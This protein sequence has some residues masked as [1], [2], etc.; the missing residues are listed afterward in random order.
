M[1]SLAFIR[2]YSLEIFTFFLD[3]MGFPSAFRWVFVTGSE[4]FFSGSPSN[5][6][7]KKTREMKLKRKQRFLSLGG[8]CNS[9]YKI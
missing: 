7:K 2:F 4:T 9:V 1:E 6:K 3:F 8:N 5:C